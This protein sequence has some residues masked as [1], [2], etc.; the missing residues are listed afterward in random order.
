MG[1][2]Q[3]IRQRM[4]TYR[5]ILL[6]F[7]WIGTVILIIVG[8]VLA[9]SQ[10]TKG[11]G[12][13]IIIGSVVIGVIGHFLINVTLAI[14]FILLNNGDILES[15]NGNV[16]KPSTFTNKCPFCN[17]EIKKEDI[18]CS[19]CGKNIQEYKLSQMDYKDLLE[20]LLMKYPV[21]I[22]RDI[23]E[24]KKNEGIEVAKEEIIKKLLI[25]NT[26]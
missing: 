3:E 6:V 12:T 1:N 20:E 10:H 4:E 2:N 15:M 11:I 5:S 17:K 14:P 23:E 19:S 16:E 7:N 13:G 8:F 26:K 21:H 24:I 9:N 22:R 25:K 18:L